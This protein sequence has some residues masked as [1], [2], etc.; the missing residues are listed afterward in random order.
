MWVMIGYGIHSFVA[1]IV[2]LGSI[3]Y[4]IYFPGYKAKGIESL[5]VNKQNY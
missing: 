5:G 3:G 1:E 2:K 4:L